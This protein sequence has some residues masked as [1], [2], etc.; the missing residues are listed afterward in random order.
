[1]LLS[2]LYGLDRKY[3]VLFQIC[4]RAGISK[5][6]NEVCMVRS[7]YAEVKVPFLTFCVFL[8]SIDFLPRTCTLQ[9]DFMQIV[10]LGKEEGANPLLLGCWK[11]ACV[12]M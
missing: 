3:V 8:T 9:L 10:Q 6:R 12:L 5:R 7:Q 2:E 4:W 11:L 1:M